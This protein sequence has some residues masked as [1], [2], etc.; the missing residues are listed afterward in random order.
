ML[1][2]TLED[3]KARRRQWE[4]VADTDGN[5]ISDANKDKGR[6]EVRRLTALIAE[7]EAAQALLSGDVGDMSI[8]F[9]SSLRDEKHAE[10]KRLDVMSEGAEKGSASRVEMAAA[11]QKALNLARVLDLAIPTLAA[12]AKQRR[13]KHRRRGSHYA[14]VAED[15]MVQTERPL[16]DTDT[17]V[18]YRDRDTGRHFVR[19]PEEF[20]DGR[21]EG[22]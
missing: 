7:V 20:A 17:V 11:S 14:V 21:F 5:V 3:L 4:V 19:P 13:V 16:R 9:L 6:A 12:I 8:L 10:V 22:A 18:I 15:G 1:D 2:N